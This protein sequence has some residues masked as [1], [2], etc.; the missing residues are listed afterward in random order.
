MVKISDR[1]FNQVD[2]DHG[3]E[4][5]N[6]IGKS[7]G[8]IIGITRSIPA[9]NRWALS[10]CQRTVIAE[11]TCE[12]YGIS[13][14]TAEHKESTAARQKRDLADEQSISHAIQG[15]KIFHPNSPD[16]LINAVNDSATPDIM[17]DLVTVE[18][19]GETLFQNFM[20]N[21]FQKNG[22]QSIHDPITKNRSKTFS[23]LYN[24]Q[25]TSKQ[26][27][28]RPMVIDRSFHHRVIVAL[29]SG[30]KVDMGALLSQEH[31]PVPLAIAEMNGRLRTCTAKS[32]LI[33]ILTTECSIA[34]P[35]SISLDRST[36]TTKLIIDGQARTMAIG[37]PDNASTFNCLANV[38]V[39]SIAASSRGYDQT[40]VLFDRYNETTIKSTTRARRS[41]QAVGIRRVI[42]DGTEKLPENWKNFLAVAEN[43]SDLSRHLSEKIV[44]MPSECGLFVTSGGFSNPVT[45]R[46]NQP[47][48]PASLN[49][50]SCDHEECDTRII[51]DAINS[52]VDRIIIAASDTD[53]LVLLLAHFHRITSREVWLL[54]SGK[55]RRYIPVHAIAS[56]L[57]HGVLRNIA[58]FHSFTGTHTTSQFYGI[59]KRSA[60]E[61]SSITLIVNEDRS[62]LRDIVMASLKE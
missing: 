50:L 48:Q 40:D 11:R 17:N 5:L 58:R 12:L 60:W 10:F 47:V 13:R 16:Q 31:M 53:V 19:R 62:L 32:E 42:E 55:K 36:S 41:G 2:G 43:K 52:E 57:P 45:A 49:G 38:Y 27:S 14:R 56:Q 34:C 61:V 44:Q 23:C 30:R 39:E 28:E 37:K 33:D 3:Q 24:V 18:K 8:G 4:W 26:A 54:I 59:S 9:L 29:S 1:K 22:S 6:G 21:R 15:M 46:S 35:T 25:N 7:S 51:Y 20:R